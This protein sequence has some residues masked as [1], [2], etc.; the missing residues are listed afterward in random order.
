MRIC[1]VLLL[2]NPEGQQVT[3]A[4][5]LELDDSNSIDGEGGQMGLII[6]R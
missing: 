6:F 2:Q 3:S 1:F 4:S 5:I